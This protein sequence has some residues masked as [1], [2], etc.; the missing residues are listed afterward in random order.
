MVT[1]GALKSIT[2]EL[3]CVLNPAVRLVSG[4][5]KFDHGLSRVLHADLHWLG[6]A[7]QI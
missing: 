7:D 4:M 5:L 2:D 6:V 1:A 3:H